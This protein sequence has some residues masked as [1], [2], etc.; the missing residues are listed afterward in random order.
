[1]EPHATTQRHGDGV[2]TVV[3]IGPLSATGGMAS[4]MQLQLDATLGADYVLVPFDNSKRTPL[5]RTLWQGVCSQLRLMFELTRLL[6]RV[7]PRLVHIHTCS[8]PTFYRSTL[9]V[10]LAKLF[11][12]KVIV[13]IHGGRFVAFLNEVRALKRW[14]VVRCLQWADCVITLSA[15]WRERIRACDHTIHL[16]VVPNGVVLPRK[17]EHRSGD[18]GLTILFVGDL[19]EVKGIDDLLEA[20]ATLPQELR[21]KLTVEVIGP[22][23]D[24]RIPA[25]Q[26]KVRRLKLQGQVEFA[27]ALPPQQVQEALARATI[28]ALPSHSEAMPLALL[29]AMAHSLPA[30]AS[31]VGA[32]PEV[33]RSGIDGFLMPP[34]DQQAL[35]EYLALLA[36]DADLRC[37]IGRAARQRIQSEYSRENFAWQLQEVYRETMRKGSK[38]VAG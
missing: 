38:C 34:G 23:R 19:R 25:L 14:W 35:A 8:A 32:I 9:D 1:M 13:H 7:R 36:S 31:A 4:V 11:G 27:G 2:S 22:D 10:V 16:A 24:G 26:D 18:Q 37:K 30:V 21:C 6:Q 15:A 3:V 12:C 33:V 29:E 5:R 17:V 28:F 20:V